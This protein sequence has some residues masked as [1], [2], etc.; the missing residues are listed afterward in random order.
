MLFTEK[1]FM[2]NEKS[3]K[4]NSKSENKQ[5]IICFEL[6]IL[7]WKITKVYWV[8]GIKGGRTQLTFKLLSFGEFQAPS[9]NGITSFIWFQVLIVSFP[10]QEVNHLLIGLNEGLLFCI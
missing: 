4:L 7:L 6:Y 1:D 10:V 2:K 9:H 3:G 5:E 8:A